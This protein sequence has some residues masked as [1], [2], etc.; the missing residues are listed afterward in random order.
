MADRLDSPKPPK[1]SKETRERVMQEDN[2]TYPVFY[3]RY[4]LTRN[5][6]FIERVLRAEYETQQKNVKRSLMVQKL[7]GEELD[8]LQ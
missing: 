7:L 2:I 1:I 3:Q 5:P 8:G 4:F 6:Q